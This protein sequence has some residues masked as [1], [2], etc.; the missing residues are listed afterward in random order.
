M[1]PAKVQRGVFVAN[2]CISV[3]SAA[4]LNPLF[5]HMSLAV[6]LVDIWHYLPTNNLLILF[7][8]L[9]ILALTLLI[10][11]TITVNQ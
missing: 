5:Y 3:R 6:H 1:T 8:I 4:T 7:P 2:I 11:A 10:V 9:T